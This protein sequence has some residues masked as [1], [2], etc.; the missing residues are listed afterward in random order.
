LARTPTGKNL[1]W[2]S[3]RLDARCYADD[4]WGLLLP[5]A[6]L[7]KRE[8]TEHGV[9]GAG[10][11][12]CNFQFSA[13]EEYLQPAFSV[14][15]GPTWCAVRQGGGAKAGVEGSCSRRTIGGLRWQMKG[16]TPGRKSRRVI[17]RTP[18]CKRSFLKQR[19]RLSDRTAG[20]AAVA[21]ARLVFSWRKRARGWA[22]AKTVTSAGRQGGCVAARRLCMRSSSK[23]LRSCPQSVRRTVLGDGCALS[24]DIETQLSG[25]SDEGQATNWPASWA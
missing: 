6:R 5:E 3:V 23:R 20:L 25:L 16:V 14:R 17:C 7:T 9:R 2:R 8:W 24:L 13:G 10:R 22:E 12:T 4:G 18:R 15:P 11:R 1:P 19:L 21:R